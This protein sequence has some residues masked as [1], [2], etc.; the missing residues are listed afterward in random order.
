M[1]RRRLRCRAKPRPQCRQQR[2]L[3][4][5]LNTHSCSPQACRPPSHNFR[6]RLGRPEDGAA[7]RTKP[8]PPPSVRDL[9]IT[10]TTSP[11]PPSPPTPR[12]PT[13]HARCVHDVVNAALSLL[14]RAPIALGVYQG[15]GAHFAFTS[16][17]YSDTF[18]ATRSPALHH[19]YAAVLALLCRVH[20]VYPA[21]LCTILHIHLTVVF[22]VALA[23]VSPWVQL[24]PLA[25][26]ARYLLQY[27]RHRCPCLRWTLRALVSKDATPRNRYTV[28]EPAGH[29]PL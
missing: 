18:A 25:R 11:G 4:P 20:V 10:P 7:V 8:P 9:R 24:T 16:L 22:F 5:T 3:A 21:C 17:S 2:A 12:H 15:E 26:A 29:P 6:A 19:A 13:Q 27:C 23:V 14:V 28:R 1:S